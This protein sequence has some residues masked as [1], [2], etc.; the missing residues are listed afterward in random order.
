M[1]RRKKSPYTSKNYCSLSSKYQDK[2]C[3]SKK[4]LINI[5]NYL[6]KHNKNISLS[7]SKKSLWTS[8]KKALSDVC[9]NKNEVCWLTHPKMKEML[10]SNYYLY[11]NNLEY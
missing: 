4:S 6:N 5:A 8:I 2:T 11:G 7:Q 1:V 10:G 3:F 9:D